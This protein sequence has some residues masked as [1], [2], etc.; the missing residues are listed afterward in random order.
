M[1][2]SFSEDRRDKQLEAIFRAQAADLYRFILRQVHE[3][4]LA[5]DLTSA[6]FLKAL[7]WLEQGRSQESVRGWLFATARSLIADYW[8]EHAQLALLPLEAA[9]ETPVPAEASEAQM[10][11]LQARIQRLLDGLPARER[12]ILTLRYFQGYSAA[13]IGEVLGISANHVRVLQFRALRRAALLE[14]EERSSSMTAPGLPYDEAAQHVL[15]YTKDEARGFHHHYMGTEHLL[16]GLLREG[17]APG[18]ALLIQHGIT[19]E[20]M[21]SGIAFILGRMNAARSS[22]A[23]QPMPAAPVEE[24]GFTAR[25]QHVLEMAGEEAQRRGKPAISPQDMLLA[26]LREGQGVAA[27]LLQVSA[28]RWQQVGDTLQISVIPDDE[29]K[30]VAVAADLQASLQ[31]HPDEQRFFERLSGLKQQQLSDMVARAE[32]ADAKQAQVERIITMLRQARQSHQQN[33]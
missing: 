33:R 28:V 19:L 12:N 27:M 11:S 14:A 5:E 13:E 25:T 32:G 26:I 22:P 4:A 9:V 31:Q 21:R 7:R 3:A 16:L 29:G 10:Q 18:A 17:S 2:P 23:P 24:P 8:R 15:D 6:V 20:K 30:P 1:G